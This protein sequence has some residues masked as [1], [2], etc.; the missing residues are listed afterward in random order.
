MSSFIFIVVMSAIGLMM[1]F[2]FAIALGLDI[3]DKENDN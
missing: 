2:V 1:S 3:A